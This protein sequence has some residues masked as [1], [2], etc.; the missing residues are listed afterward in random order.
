MAYAQPAPSTNCIWR[1]DRLSDQLHCSRRPHPAPNSQTEI[2][3]RTYAHVDMCFERTKKFIAYF[4]Y[5]NAT[6]NTGTGVFVMHYCDITMQRRRYGIV[7]QLCLL[8]NHDP[9]KGQ[10][11]R[12]HI[13]IVNCHPT[14]VMGTLQIFQQNPKLKRNHCH[15]TAQARRGLRGITVTQVYD[16][17]HI[18]KITSTIP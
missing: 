6:C 1:T 18:K 11:S 16:H 4:Y 12:T 10:R 8:L 2:T 3:K 5:S 15:E 7:K 9:T 17:T 13:H 14:L